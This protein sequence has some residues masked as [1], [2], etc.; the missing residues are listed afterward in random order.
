MD[1]K[2]LTENGWNAIGGKFKVKDNGLQKALAAYEKIEDDKHDERLK[3]VSLVAQL[4]GALKKVKEVALLPEV[5]KYLA[6][7][8]AAA[9]SEKSEI[10][11]AKLL[12]AKTAAIGQKKAQAEAKDQEQE[13]EEVEE[14]GAYEVKLM[15]VLKKLKGSKGLAYQFIVCDAKPMGLMVAK[16][17][18]PQHR[19]QLIKMTGS[20]R[21]FPIGTC[22]FVEGKFHFTMEKPPTG[23]ARKLQ[24]SIKNYT[25][26]K[27]PILAGTETAEAED[28]GETSAAAPAQ[29]S[30]GTPG[31]PCS[32]RATG[33]RR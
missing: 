26:K 10:A 2:L 25:G 1:A 14:E 33:P 17:I 27:L 23:L 19:A 24:E 18:T 9:E 3:A 21:F 30:A 31:R 11:K 22:S 16:K 28:E 20:K 13:E 6:S 4:A 32:A 29:A 5:I 12:A 15:A 7:V 8:A